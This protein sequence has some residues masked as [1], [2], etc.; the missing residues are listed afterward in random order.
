MFGTHIFQYMKSSRCTKTCDCITN[1]CVKAS[2][3]GSNH[4]PSYHI[5]VRLHLAVQNLFYPIVLRDSLYVHQ[6]ISRRHLF[7]TNTKTAFES[8]N[9]S[10]HAHVKHGEYAN[11]K[12]KGLAMIWVS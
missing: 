9:L 1:E 6:F 10:I 8:W 12:C 4:I 2:S 3:G 5:V 11:A 7:S